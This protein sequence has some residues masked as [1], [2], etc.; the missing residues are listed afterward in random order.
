MQHLQVAGEIQKRCVGVSDGYS[1]AFGCYQ[2]KTNVCREHALTAD[3]AAKLDAVVGKMKGWVRHLPTHDQNAASQLVCFEGSDGD[4][5]GAVAVAFALLVLVKHSPKMQFWSRCRHVLADGS[6]LAPW[7]G[8]MPECPFV[9]RISDRVGRL[10]SR[11]DGGGDMR[12][13]DIFT[14]DELA[15][16]LVSAKRSWRLFPMSYTLVEGASLMDMQALARGD[17]F[18]CAVAVRAPKAQLVK[19]PMEFDMGDPSEHGGS[20]AAHTRHHRENAR[21][22]LVHDAVGNIDCCGEYV[23]MPSDMVDDLAALD[24]EGHCIAKPAAVADPMCELLV[25][26]GEVVACESELVDAAVFVDEELESEG[27]LP[28]EECH[29]GA[30]D[31]SGSADTPVVDGSTHA[32]TLDDF[33]SVAIIDEEGWISCPLP[34]F[35]GIPHL[36][37]LTTWPKDAPPEK[38]NV[39]IRCV[40]HGG[41]CKVARRRHSLTNE[42][43]LKWLFSGVPFVPGQ[44]QAL[45]NLGRD[46][47]LLAVVKL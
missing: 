16:E 23:D 45:A 18:D 44:G 2:K 32:P 37:R 12:S 24:R 40:L 25:A 14:S 20:L 6:T 30:I 3:A 47:A 31:G 17:P 42:Q 36:G 19:L 33:V 8:Q 26:P 29:D 13:V 21:H 7:I 11:K 9:V 38:A 35:K 15:L 22:E 34:H 27:A 43:L 39:G 10:C 46:H 5:D 41:N 4:G 1:L 28:A